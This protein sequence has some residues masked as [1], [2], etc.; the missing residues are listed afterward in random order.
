[1]LAHTQKTDIHEQIVGAVTISERPASA[2]DRAV[3]GH[4]EA[5]TCCSAATT[6]RSPRWSSVRRGTSCS[7]TVV[8]A[9][10]KNARKLPEELYKSLTWDRGKEMAGGWLP[11]AV[12]DRR[13]GQGRGLLTFFRQRAGTPDV[14]HAIRR[15]VG[16]T[17]STAR[18]GESLLTNVS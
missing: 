13:R 16:R 2:E 6:A 11:G 15:H 8:N 18:Q 1:M 12:E 17:R 10:I 7:E 9:L 3:P 14:P 4:W 5:Q